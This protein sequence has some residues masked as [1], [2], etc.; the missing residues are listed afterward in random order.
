[1]NVRDF[2]DVRAICEAGSLRKAAIVLGITQPTLSSRIAYLEHQLGAA[3]FDR[4]R[5]SSR[6]TDL[7]LFIARRATGMAEQAARLNEEVTQLAAG[8]G[9]HVRIGAG[10]GASRIVGEIVASLVERIPNLGVD[11][12]AAHSA[13]LVEDLI[14]GKLDMIV[15]PPLASEHPALVSEPLLETDVVIVA[16]PEHPLCR[17]PPATL[18]GLAGFPIALPIPEPMHVESL[19]QQFGIDIESIPGRILCSDTSTL[20]HIVRGSRRRIA[21]GPRLYFMAELQAGT[22]RTIDTPVPLRHRICLHH[23]RDAYPLPTVLKVREAIRAGFAEA[24]G[25]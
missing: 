3:L 15:C 1:M 13:Q 18:A 24:A 10:P 17:K 4:R 11:I 16:C 23:S 21:A 20:V 19:R 9:G 5:G 6:P 22:L 25:G 14:A 2:L 12:Q 8:K 7:A